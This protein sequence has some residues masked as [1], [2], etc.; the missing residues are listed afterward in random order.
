M[1]CNNAVITFF[2]IDS[3]KISVSPVFASINNQ[4]YESVYEELF[5]HLAMVLFPLPL[6]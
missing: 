2:I 1:R 5:K 3:I 4:Y 6:I